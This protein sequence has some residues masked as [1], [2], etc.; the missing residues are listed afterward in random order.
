MHGGPLIALAPLRTS[1][2]IMAWV[3]GL[4]CTWLL[5]L[6]LSLVSCVALGSSHVY[7]QHTQAQVACSIGL[8]IVLATWVLAE[9]ARFCCVGESVKQS[10][11][12]V[13]TTE[14]SPE[15]IGAAEN[16]EAVT[17]PSGGSVAKA[18]DV[19]SSEDLACHVSRFGAW[20]KVWLG[21]L[22][23]GAEL[24]GI[25][26]LLYL[27]D[28]TN[29]FPKAKKVYD[30]GQFWMLWAL[31]C[32]V[33]LCTVR[34]L[35]DSKLLSREQTDEWKG[36]MQ[37]MFLMYHYFAEKEVYNAIRVYIAAYVWMTGYGN[38]FLYR[39]GKSFTFRRTVQML[40][41]LNFL[42][43]IVCVVL[44]NEYMLYYI[45]PMHTLFTLFVLL[46]LYLGQEHNDSK[47]ALWAKIIATFV[48][49]LL[50]YDGPDAVFQ[51]IFGTVPGIRHL[52]AFHDP[53]HPEFKDEMHEWHFRSGL[54]R[55]IWIVGM[56]FALHFPD[57]DAAIAHL[58]DMA[59]NRRLSIQIV[60]ASLALLAGAAWAQLVFTQEKSIYNQLH[61]YTSFI[62]ITV[63]LII[64][65]LTA[66]LRSR[67]LWLFAY[68]GK[69]TLETYIFQFHIWMKTTGV[70][71]S[72]KHLLQVVP[73]GYYWLNFVVVS[74][75]YIFLS[76]RF[77]ALTGVLRDTLIPEDN[78]SICRVWLGLIIFMAVCFALSMLRPM[79]DE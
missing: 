69:V 46:V 50:L 47:K 26:A 37:I 11:S 9:T 64:R 51:G 10:Y 61:P 31:I 68:L 44:N 56:V 41:R 77:C 65:N 6:A 2:I 15:P 1:I 25:L 40:F 22:R 79:G 39:R 53:L 74:A 20:V 71:G 72:P 32:F 33:A 42:G 19:E 62:P 30:P 66:A 58:T 70:N 3:I 21:P 14:P 45:C 27:C 35:G 23:A 76:V 54:D 55:F 49:T 38:F 43:F 7:G 34:K 52:F 4:L 13:A 60:L 12:Q 16:G 75:A 73:G 24:A 63:Y 48:G 78:W 28:R 57:A 8:C 17:A 5:A 29:Y 36:W 18:H 67:Y 59:G